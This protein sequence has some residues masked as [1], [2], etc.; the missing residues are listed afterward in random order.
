MN[1][2][3]KNEPFV[4]EVTERI[5][6]HILSGRIRAAT[7]DD[8]SK[9]QK[10]HQLGKCDHSIVYD[11]PGWLYDFRSCYVCGQGLGTI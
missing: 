7:S 8:I 9:C 5:G 2:N 3:Q 10:L 4:E 1:Q 11:I 6:K